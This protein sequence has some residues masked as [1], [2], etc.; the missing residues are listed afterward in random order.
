MGSMGSIN[1]LAK[2]IYQQQIGAA[3]ANF[4]AIKQRSLR[5]QSQGNRGLTYFPPDRCAALNQPVFLKPSGYYRGA[6]SRQAG[7]PCNVSFCGRPIAAQ[8]R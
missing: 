2:K 3:A 5:G 8:Q 7:Y 6:L 1:R 4:Q